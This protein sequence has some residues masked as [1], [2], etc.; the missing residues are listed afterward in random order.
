MNT[1]SQRVSALIAD[2]EALARQRLRERL[3]QIDW[4]DLVGETEDGPDTV[5]EVDRLRPDLVFLDIHLPGLSGLGVLEHIMHRPHV[6]FTAAD[7]RYAA[8]AFDLEAVDYL[9]K[10]L[11]RPRLDAALLRVKQ[12]L[13]SAN[14]TGP[15]LERASTNGA[16]P[17]SRVLVRRADRMIP[18][19]VGDITRLEADGDYVRI[20]T[21][22]GEQY[23]ASLR[24]QDFER[25][26]DSGRFMRI[27]RSHIVNLD[28]V[29]WFNSL[30]GGRL[31]VTM[32]DGSQLSVSRTKSRE[33]RRLAI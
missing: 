9:L 30:P 32:C 24:M 29:T 21:I 33:L 14:G 5:T 25:R 6:V 20:Y 19:S 17:L 11:T 12:M 27:H 4:I 1:A 18:V 8:V 15:E 28:C 23:L 26:L 2:G 3:Q 22:A 7:D 31:Q 10:P 13:R 16:A